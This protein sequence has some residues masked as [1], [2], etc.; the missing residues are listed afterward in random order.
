ML[1]AKHEACLI[2]PQTVV[3]FVLESQVT[4]QFRIYYYS[5]VFGSECLQNF[6]LEGGSRVRFPA[7][8]GNFSL[9]RS[10]QTGSGAHPAF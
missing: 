9:H 10:V 5:V 7:G 4:N 1:V 6:V 3:R 2:V 8:A